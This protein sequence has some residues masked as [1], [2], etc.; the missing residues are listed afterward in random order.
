MK[1]VNK[2]QVVGKLREAK[3]VVQEKA[4][5]LTDNPKLQAKG[6]GNQLA[7]KGQHMAGDVEQKIEKAFDKKREP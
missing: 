3:G 6:L 5:K 7:G 1:S 2:D 4:G